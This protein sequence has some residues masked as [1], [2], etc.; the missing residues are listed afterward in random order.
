MRISTAQMYQTTAAT[1]SNKQLDLARIQN[2]LSTGKRIASLADDPAAAAGAAVLRSDL[3]ANSQLDQ[4][5]Q[6]AQQN[7]SFA[8]ATLGSVGDNLQSLRELMVSAGN[9]GYND[10]DRKTIAGQ[11]REGLATL[12]GLANTATGQ[13]GYLF[14]GFREDAPPFVQNGMAVNYVADDGTRTLNVSANRTMATAFNGA[15]VFM[16]IPNGNGVFTSSAVAGNSGTGLVD[17]GRVTNAAALTGNN[18]EVRFVVGAGGTT[19]D[20]IDTTTNTAV[21]AGTPYA[22]PASI[23]LPGMS[24]NIS[25]APANGDK[26]AVVPS[27]NQNVFATISN[28]IALLETPA[29]G[30]TT[31]IN[32][33]LRVALTNMDQAISHISDQRGMAGTRLNELDKLAVLGAG[34][35]VDMASTLSSLEDIDYV[36]TISD[37]TVAQTGLQAALQSYAKI[38]KSSLLDYIP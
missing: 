35:D 18:Y 29:N 33:G 17:G 21:S 20:V 8:E 19:Y 13:G 24:V 6:V 23:T 10:A 36:K 14:G 30:N 26:F 7:L 34:R 2:Q 22:A 31:T 15:D 32:N 25:G 5:R 9:G 12:I 3:A 16:R 28:A 11:L 38:A 37:F 27:G 1:I 4:N